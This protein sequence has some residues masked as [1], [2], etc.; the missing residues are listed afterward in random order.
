MYKAAAV[1]AAGELLEEIRGCQEGQ[2]INHKLLQT[3][4][5]KGFLLRIVRAVVVALGLT[6][7]P[8][9]QVA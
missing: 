7:R 1:A 6:Y 4:H 2:P 3:L 9:E 5:S 8:R